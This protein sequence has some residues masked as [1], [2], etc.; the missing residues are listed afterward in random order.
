MGAV[1]AL[2]PQIGGPVEGTLF[3]LF[4]FSFIVYVIKGR[5]TQHC[6]MDAEM[7]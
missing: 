7:S 1:G 4:V 6:L 2:G 5:K 3:G